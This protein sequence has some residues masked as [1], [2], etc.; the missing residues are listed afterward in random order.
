MLLALPLHKLPFHT[1]LAL[2]AAQRS[3][4]KAVA[5]PGAA[6]A[7]TPER[8]TAD[9]TQDAAACDKPRAC[10]RMYLSGMTVFTRCDLRTRWMAA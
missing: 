7:L 2:A 4:A 10:G 8:M 5:S 6:A 3:A 1:Y 9:V